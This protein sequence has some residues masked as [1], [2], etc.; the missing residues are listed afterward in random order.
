MSRAPAGLSPEPPPAPGRVAGATGLEPVLERTVLAS[1][2][3]GV[4]RVKAA[5]RRTFALLTHGRLIA[6]G[7]TSETT[8]AVRIDRSQAQSDRDLTV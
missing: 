2:V 1:R 8:T 6:V 7:A 5:G 4:V 3:S